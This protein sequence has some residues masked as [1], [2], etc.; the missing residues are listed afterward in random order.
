MG[1]CEDILFSYKES[2]VIYF[3]CSR[4][5]L[6]PLQEMTQTASAMLSHLQHT[7][8]LYSVEAHMAH[9]LSYDIFASSELYV[10]CM[11]SYKDALY[12][13]RNYH[14]HYYQ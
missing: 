6:F 11:R 10:L 4:A 2:V 7:S 9:R 1:K 3:E 14:L 8:S 13:N 5:A 12:L